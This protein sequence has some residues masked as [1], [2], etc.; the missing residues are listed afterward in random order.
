VKYQIRPSSQAIKELERLDRTTQKRLKNRI[1]ELAGN[2]FDPRLS[3]QLE[4][5]PDK[6][7]S[8]AGNWRIIF[9]VNEVDQV[10]EVAAVQHRS[11]VYKK[12]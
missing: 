1:E 4:I 6:R 2:P 3:R 9:V 8:R 11:R 10:L 5:A 7:Y 12:L